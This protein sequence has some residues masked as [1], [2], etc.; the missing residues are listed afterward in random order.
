MSAPNVPEGRQDA[1]Y[2]RPVLPELVNLLELELEKL[3]GP[4]LALEGSDPMPLFPRLDA[5]A[6]RMIAER[7]ADIFEQI[8][9]V[10]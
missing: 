10:R 8:M 7:M 4:L 5:N 9:S 6:R 3:H 1:E 2:V